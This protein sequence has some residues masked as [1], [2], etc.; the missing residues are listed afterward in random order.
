MTRP[1]TPAQR[2]AAAL[3]AQGYRPREVCRAVG[4]QANVLRYWR[5]VMEFQEHLAQCQE[6]YQASASDR[7]AQM[8]EAEAEAI[9]RAVLDRAREGDMRAL[10][11]AARWLERLGSKGEE[12]TKP[13]GEE[14]GEALGGLLR[15]LEAGVARQLVD[16]LEA[17]AGGEPEAGTLPG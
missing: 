9:V 12:Q 16:Y 11:L 13:A 1:L 17:T 3:L 15:G 14:D 4:V 6:R 10:A 8:V 7:V 5:G 2:H